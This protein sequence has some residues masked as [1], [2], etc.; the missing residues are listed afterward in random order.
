MAN[1]KQ[2]YINTRF[3]NDSY[4]SELDPIEK[5]LFIYFLTNEHTNIS[6]IYELPQKIIGIETGIDKSMIHKILP[7]L[8]LKIR[9]IN[10]YVVIKN[11]IKHQETPSEFV[12]KGI[13]NCL[14]ELDTKWL[15]NVVKQGFY[16]LPKEYS[17]TLCIPYI[18]SLSYSNS[19][20][21]S[22]SNS[23]SLGLGN[24]LI[25]EIFNLWNSYPTLNGNCK[26]I[27]AK[28][29]LLPKCEKTTPDI[30]SA[31]GKLKDYKIEDMKL[32]LKN[33]I[34]DI[35]NRSPENDYAKHRFSF[36]EFFK[37]ANGFKKYLN[38]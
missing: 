33:Y 5:L 28:K 35:I 25:Q 2:R 30:V 38:K 3:W 32:S 29:K 23:I 37:Q 11:F 31:F 17:D 27:T 15:E 1:N 20:S 14:K 16:I 13:L 7:R 21:N 34:Q 8:K 19:N 24:S 26:N 22:N 9:Y 10:G 12:K 4:I 36:Y 18:E 6:G